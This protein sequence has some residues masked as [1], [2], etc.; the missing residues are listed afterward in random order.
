MEKME[1]DSNKIFKEDLLFIHK[2]INTNYF[3]NKKILITGSEGFLGFYLK[4]YFTNY[5]KKLKLSKLYLADLNLKKK[6]YLKKIVNLKFDVTKDK[7]EKISKNLDI[8]IHAASIASP[9][10]YR[11]HPL[12]TADSNV[13]G[14]RKLLE[15]S[16][17]RSSKVKILY[18]STSE[19]YGDPPK[20]NIP[21]DENYRG[22]VSCT[23]PRAC[24]D[25]S[26]RFSE[27]L[28]YIYAKY[29]KVPVIVVR[30]FNNYG[31][32]LK[33]SDGRLQAELGNSIIRNK[34]IMLFS[35]GKPT[36]SF[37]YITDAIIGYLKAL[38][39]PKYEIFNIGNDKDEISVLSL[40]KLYKKLGQ[41]YINYTSQI[42]YK[43]NAD[44]NYLTD[45]PNRR[46]PNIKKAKKLLKF[47]PKISIKEGIK[48]YL[49]YLKNNFIKKH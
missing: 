34:N 21:T 16:K 6:S 32:G 38:S 44:K 31:P 49:F 9:V 10:T 28:C 19:I 37:C 47:S 33:I 12:K 20:E 5:F 23:G 36:R 18:F 4:N 13:L 8:I 17:S 41:K 3:R 39:Y 30:P 35:S 15:Y 29:F 25:E 46:C 24:Y 1:I 42:I 45:N 22:N 11:K 27:T 26:K 2:N 48:R 40:A 43:K 7:V 14:L